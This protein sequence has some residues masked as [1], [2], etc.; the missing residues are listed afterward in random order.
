[1]KAIKDIMLNTEEMDIYN[2]KII[3]GE[4][5]SKKYILARSGIGKVNAARTTQILIDNFN[6]DHIINV[7]SAGGLNDNLNIGDIIIGEKLV[8]HDFDLTAFGRKKG[9]IPD[10]G[11]FFESD[12][13]LIKK[14][15]DI[16]VENTNI[17]KGVIAS[18]DIFCTN[19][20]M[21]EKIRKKFRADCVEMEGAAIAHVCS[22]NKTPFIVIRSISDIPN[23]KNE[24][25]FN[26]FLDF[27]S[28]KCA[29]FIS[30]I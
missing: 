3:T 24:I 9:D 12:I 23:N 2:L 25:D 27:A 15:E 28:K 16:S 11:R 22:L 7:G 4:I 17:I 20:E 8:E 10:A 14:T 5:N 29:E 1:M 21:K 19:I 6:I 18:G 26:K 30:K 13:N